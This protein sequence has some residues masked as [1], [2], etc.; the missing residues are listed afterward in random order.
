MNLSRIAIVS[1]LLAGLLAACGTRGALDAPEGAPKQ[2]SDKSIT[3]DK[4][5]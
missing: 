5:I 4:I 1:L 3:L 2:P